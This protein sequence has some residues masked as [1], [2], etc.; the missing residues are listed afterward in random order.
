MVFSSKS[1]LAVRQ[2]I[3]NIREVDQ[4][5]KYLGMPMMVGRSKKPIFSF[6]RDRL[7]KR[8]SGWIEKFL[9]RAWR[10]VLIKSIAQ[11]IPTYIMSCLALPVSF[12]SDMQGIISK[13]WWSGSKDKRKI[14]WVSWHSICQSK[15]NGGLGFRNLRA[16][17][18]G[19]LAKQAWRLVQNPNSLCTKI[20][21]AKYHPQSDFRDVILRRGTSNLWQSIIEGKKI[22]V[23]SLAW[24]IGN[25]I[26][27]NAKSDN[28]ITTTNLMK[29]AV[30]TGYYRACN[31]LN[32][33]NAGTSCGGD[34]SNIW[35]R[36]GAVRYLQNCPRCG[37]IEETELHA[38][39]IGK[40][41]E[42]PGSYL[43]LACS[44]PN[45]LKLNTD[46]S[47]QVGKKLSV[48]S[49]VIQDY[50]C[51]VVSSGVTLAHGVL[52]VETAKALV[53]RCGLQ[54]PAAI[55]ASTLIVESDSTS[56][57]SRLLH[58]EVAIDPI[59]SIVDD[60][61]VLVGDRSFCFQY[62]SRVCNQV[63]DALAKWGVFFGHDCLFTGEVPYPINDLFLKHIPKMRL[64]DQFESLLIKPYPIEFDFSVQTHHSIVAF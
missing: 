16:F 20:L 41:F 47:V 49:A 27:A 15:K 31:S 8:V 39:K 37:L 23:S 28:W 51:L 44:P 45:V 5:K 55:S 21:K 18:Q 26:Y 2:E 53:V 48:I 64:E 11:S 3:L 62:V 54:L 17:N 56:V 52:D 46:A 25:G 14:P 7:H 34:G 58:P 63:A 30:K 4:F 1:P 12:C 59:Q 33:D 50:A 10:E 9:S 40:R 42:G 6:P 22:L 19:M 61:L 36:F 35:R 24:R 13:L 57:I 32:R 60:C 38:L 43:E 29:P